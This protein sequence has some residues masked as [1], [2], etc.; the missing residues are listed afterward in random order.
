MAKRKGGPP[1]KY[2]KGYLSKIKRKDFLGRLSEAEIEIAKKNGLLRWDLWKK[3]G[4]VAT[5]TGDLHDKGWRLAPV[6]DGFG[7]LDAKRYTLMQRF[8]VENYADLAAKT[9]INTV[10][11]R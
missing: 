10:K 4:K 8:L 11:N 6:F 2:T 7:N 9:A 1:K 5:L 3:A